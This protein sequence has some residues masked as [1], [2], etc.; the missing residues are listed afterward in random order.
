MLQF[1]YFHTLV[2]WQYKLLRLNSLTHQARLQV[3]SFINE[4][5]RL[6]QNNNEI[7]WDIWILTLTCV[8]AL[9]LLWS[10]NLFLLKVDDESVLSWIIYK[11]LFCLFFRTLSMYLITTYQLIPNTIWTNRLL[12]LCS[13]YL[14]LFL[15]RRKRN[16]CC[17]VSGNCWL[18][19]RLGDY[20]LFK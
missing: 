17:F 11:G 8:Q 3:L 9:L 13:E 18:K 14:N 16:L 15:E 5:H 7:L 4:V 20:L 2:L 19:K 6:H 12:N 10:R 1:Q